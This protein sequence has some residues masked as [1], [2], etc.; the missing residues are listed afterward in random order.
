MA[1]GRAVLAGDHTYVPED[2]RRMPG[3]VTLRQ[4][5]ETQSRPSYFRGCQQGAVCL[6]VGTF[7]A[8]FGLPLSPGIHQ[9]MEHITDEKEEKKDCDNLK[10]RIIQ[11]A[12]DFTVRHNQPCILTLDAYFPGASVSIPANSFWSIELKQPLVTLIIR[13]EKKLRGLP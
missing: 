9:G 10:T 12:L 11:T 2:G 4:N 3:V 6:M 1:E 7:T 8:P 13:A 5:S